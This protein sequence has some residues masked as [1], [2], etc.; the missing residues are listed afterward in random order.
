MSPSVTDLLEIATAEFRSVRRLLGEAGEVALDR[1]MDWLVDD[2]FRLDVRGLEKVPTEGAALLV[3]NHSGAWGL[4]AFVFQRVLFRSLCRPLFIPAAPLTFRVPA[5]GAYARKKGAYPIDPT[6]GLEHLTAGE[7]VGLFPEGMAGLE[8]PFQDRYR[9]RPFSPGFA[10]TALR[11]GAPVLPVAIVGAEETY[12]KLGDVPALARLLD[13]PYFPITPV[14]PLPAKWLISIGEPIPA[15]ERPASLA[16]RSAV[17]RALCAEARAA[18]QDMLDE[19]VGGRD[20]PF[21]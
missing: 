2:Y 21:W 8:K 1:T 4:D 17:A 14:F 18:V 16:A 20:T 10:A 11:A 15:P 12:P 3:A 19:V 5:L 7:L 13:L 9:L 6:L